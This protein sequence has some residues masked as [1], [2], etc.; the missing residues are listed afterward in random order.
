[1]GT[2]PELF[3]SLVFDDRIM[4]A[5]LPADV[6]ASL[7]KTIDEGLDGRKAG[8]EFEPAIPMLIDALR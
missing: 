7:R 8:P 6:Y 2:L 5:S 1:M 3:G 4:R